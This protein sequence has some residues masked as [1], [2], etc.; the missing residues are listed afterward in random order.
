[1]LLVLLVPIVAAALWY[2]RPEWWA[3]QIGDGVRSIK[4]WNLAAL[5]WVGLIV[6]SIESR[7][8]F[9][10]ILAALV[11]L[12]FWIYELWILVHQGDDAFPGRNDK[13]IWAVVLLILS[14]ISVWLFRSYHAAHWP[15]PKSVTHPELDPEPEGR[16]S[17][18][19]PV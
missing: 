14:P 6:A 13:L 17:A 9:G 7:L 4:A 5:L 12:Y 11:F 18:T 10:L 2:R 19:M 15:E 8:S 3:R 1:M 16:R